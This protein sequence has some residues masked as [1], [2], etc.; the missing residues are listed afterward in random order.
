MIFVLVILPFISLI[1]AYVQLFQSTNTDFLTTL[2]VNFIILI[3]GS[4]LLKVYSDKINKTGQSS[5][6]IGLGFLSLLFLVIS[7]Y[8]LIVHISWTNSFQL[9]I[10]ELS[11]ENVVFSFGTLIKFFVFFFFAIGFSAIGF[12][13]ILNLSEKRVELNPTDGISDER[14]IYFKLSLIALIVLPLLIF[15]NLMSQSKSTLSY[16]VFILIGLS[17]ILILIIC[18]LI[19]F[20]IKEYKFSQMKWAFY[21]MILLIVLL[22]SV[23]QIS[24]A[25]ANLKESV[26]LADRYNKYEEALKVKLGR[27]VVKISGEEIFQGRCSACHKFDVKLVGPPYNQTLPKYVGKKEQLVKFILNPT[28]VDPAYPPMPAQGLKPQ[29][30]EAVA[31]F[32]LNS[33]KNK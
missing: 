30:A 9:S 19:Y 15:L 33:F 29:E 27:T 32:L 25:N 1:F 14:K 21:L 23:D 8:F 3:I 7:I 6:P 18:N 11:F 20:Q 31:E 24:F 12:Q 17:L 26:L 22:I 16:S 28:K 5:A 4:V 2:S 10:S 13:V